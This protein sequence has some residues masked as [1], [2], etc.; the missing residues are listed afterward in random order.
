MRRKTGSE[1]ERTKL[2]GLRK[3]S[4][5]VRVCTCCSKFLFAAYSFLLLASSS[6]ARYIYISGGEEM[7]RACVREC[8]VPPRRVCAPLQR[9]GG[10][11]S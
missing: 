11:E 6:L 9:V 2:A 4:V 10:G 5:V 8:C 1:P 7:P 3:S